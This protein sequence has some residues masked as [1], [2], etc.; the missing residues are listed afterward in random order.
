MI[1]LDRQKKK[2]HPT[3]KQGICDCIL[4]LSCISEVG[5]VEQDCRIIYF[6]ETPESEE[7]KGR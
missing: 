7:G 5:E 1:S 4:M 3:E 6:Q 2:N